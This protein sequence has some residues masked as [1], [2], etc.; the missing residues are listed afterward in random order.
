VSNNS[1]SRAR[2]GGAGGISG[3]TGGDLAEHRIGGRIAAERRK[4]L[5]A[6]PCVGQV[7]PGKTLLLL[8]FQCQG[9]LRGDRL[10]QV[11]LPGRLLASRARQEHAP[12]M[13]SGFDRRP[14]R[15]PQSHQRAD[16]WPP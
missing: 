2:S 9:Q 12:E 4:N 5:F 8:P 7:F 3:T 15:V 13:A 14:Q 10:R 16:N 11:A 1:E 6:E